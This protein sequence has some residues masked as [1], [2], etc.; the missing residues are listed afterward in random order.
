MESS[1]KNE[2]YGLEALDKVGASK[3]PNSPAPGDYRAEACG[4]VEL[5]IK[6]D[7]GDSLSIPTGVIFAR[8]R[9]GGAVTPIAVKLFDERYVEEEGGKERRFTSPFMGIDPH[10]LGAWAE[11]QGSLP[12]A[13]RDTLT[14]TCEKIMRAGYNGAKPF[15]QRVC[16]VTADR[17]T[18]DAVKAF[19]G[20]TSTK[21]DTT[22]P[23]TTNPDTDEQGEQHYFPTDRLL[24]LSVGVLSSTD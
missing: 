3:S 8:K 7:N 5:S 10:D 9:D 6:F 22:K 4:S 2:A 21:P 24:C 14:V 1:I 12:W 15:R 17:A 19:T 23:D 16:M 11:A 20:A 13:E 18:V